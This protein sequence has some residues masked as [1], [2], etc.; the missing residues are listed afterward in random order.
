M[1][2]QRGKKSTRRGLERETERGEPRGRDGRPLLS[3][4]KAINALRRRAWREDR[5]GGCRWIEPATRPGHVTAPPRRAGKGPNISPFSFPGASRG[6]G[7][8]PARRHPGS[9]LYFVSANLDNPQHLDFW[10]P[11][12]NPSQGAPRTR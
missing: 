8:G 11:S 1:H 9:Y 7:A 5:A 6:P 4:W 10:F 12:K 3:S 2:A